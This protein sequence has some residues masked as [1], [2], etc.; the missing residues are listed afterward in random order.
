MVKLKVEKITLLLIIAFTSILPSL[1]IQWNEP[2][3]G[4]QIIKL[5]AKVGS[6]V[7][8]MILIWQFL[9]GFRGVLAWFVPDLLWLISL[10]KKLGAYGTLLILLHPVFIGIYY[11]LKFG[12][13]VYSFQIDT[14]LEKY[15][16]WGMVALGLIAFIVI[17]SVF[18]RPHMQEWIWYY[19]H[20]SSYLVLPV[21]LIH[22][23]RIGMTIANTPLGILW[24][25]LMGGVLLLYVFRVLFRLGLTNRKYTVVQTVSVADQTTEISLK[26]VHDE[27]TPR[28][29]Q[30][31][32]FHKDILNGARPYTVSDYHKATGQLAVTIKA[33]GKTSKKHQQVNPGERIILDGPYGVFT[34]EALTTHRPVVMIAGGIGIT[35]F[36]RLYHRLAEESDRKSFLFYGNTD[37]RNIAYREE[38]KPLDHLNVVHVISDEP[39]YPGEKGYITT[40]LLSRYLEADLNQYEFFLCGPPIMIT[41]L[42]HE[43]RNQRVPDRQIHHELFSY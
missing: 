2:T 17:T 26:P 22:G 16:L 1:F 40:E 25:V 34:W 27:I 33:L 18:F 31:I 20:L 6:L 4:L 23:Y 30:F 42:E 8:A 13:N 38:L 19:T 9:L 10:H 15:I 14:L 39:E 41:K 32:F 35:P 12:I 43:L 7:G 3:P 24:Q 29:G 36:R 11:K 21:V 37:S 5:V 28:I